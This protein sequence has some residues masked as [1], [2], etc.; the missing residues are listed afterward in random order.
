MACVK[1]DIDS[2]LG[3][4]ELLFWS[5][6]EKCVLYSSMRIFNMLEHYDWAFQNNTSLRVQIDIQ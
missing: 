1:I 3:V 2:Q 5:Y 4:A 6:S